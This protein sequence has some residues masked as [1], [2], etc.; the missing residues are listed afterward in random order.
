MS[1]YSFRRRKSIAHI[2]LPILPTLSI[3]LLC[4][5]ADSSNEAPVANGLT[6]FGEVS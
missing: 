1:S 3:K 2:S 5:R 4:F 6:E